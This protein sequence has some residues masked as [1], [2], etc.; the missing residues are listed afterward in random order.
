MAATTAV[1]AGTAALAAGRYGSGFALKPS[2]AGP[3]PESKVG[4]HAVGRDRIVLT[5]TAA[6]ARTGV[7]GLA[8]EGLH[9]AVGRVVEQ[10]DTTVTRR[11]L[12]IDEG[13]LDAGSAVRMTPQVYCG[14]PGSA[15]GLD[16][17]D[18]E[19]RGELGPLPAWFVPGVRSTW[20]IAVH[21][22]GAT[23]EHVLNVVPAL[24]RFRL[25]H[26]VLSYR[27]DPGAPASPDGIGH[28]GETEWRD[29]D[30]AMRYA[31]SYHPGR[32]VLY[33]WGTGATMA[34]RAL[35]QSPVRERV[36]GLV[37]DSP[38]LDWR[39][40]VRASVSARGLPRVL[41]PLAV[42]AAEG[43][44]GLH[45]ARHTGA[46]QPDRLTVPTLLVHGPDDTFASWTR[47]RA[48][49]DGRADTVAL[50]TVPGAPHAAMWNA[51]PKAYEEALRRFLTPLM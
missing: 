28:L 27:N 1:G 38:V 2:L 19:V 11:L 48:F 50:H 22:A 16:F 43:R 35:A 20:V 7:H 26:L 13:A 32:I 21:G 17:T 40:T 46:V 23:R 12:R 9:A 10:D 25:P 49:A 5:R 44:A 14:D 31:A 41:T 33:G 4:V 24:S 39:A 34:L 36:G 8:G 37:L 3:A 15:F 42:R 18:V 51:D 47:S 6:S 45:A 29:L 30:A